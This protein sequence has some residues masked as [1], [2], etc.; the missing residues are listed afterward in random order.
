MPE[1]SPGSGPG[2]W[3]LAATVL[4]A[5][6]VFL[7]GSGVSIALPSIQS[8]FAGQLSGLQWVVNAYLLTLAALLPIGGS[9][10]DRFGRKRVLL[11]GMI[12]FASAGVLSAFARSIVQLTAFQAIQGI[13]SALVVPQNLAI[14][15]V[16]FAEGKRGQVI[17]L[18][19]G[20]SGAVSALGPWVSGWLVEHFSWSAVFFLSVLVVVAAFFISYVFVPESRNQ[21]ARRVDWLGASLL[22]AALFG[23]VYGLISGPSDWTS[24]LVLVSLVGGVVLFLLFIFAEYH[25]R[26]PAVPLRIFRSPLVSGANAATLM[27]YTALNGITLFSV[28]NLQQVHGYSP[29]LAGLALLPT[30]VCITLLSAPAGSMADRNGPRLQMVV[31]PLLVAVG[32]FWLSAWAYSG[33]YLLGFFPG[34]LVLGLGMA[35]LIAPLTKSALLVSPEL[36]G[37]ASGVNNAVSRVAS[38]LA[39]AVLGAIMLSLFSARLSDSLSGSGLSGDQQLAI[40]AQAG[41]LGGVVIPDGFDVVARANAEHVV[42]DSFEYAYRWAMATCSALALGGAVVSL[43]T[44]RNPSKIK[45]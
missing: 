20:L 45:T 4:S 35:T 31:G 37:A 23:I 12:V 19:A 7:L 39:V 2:R 21:H 16:S 5:A 40:S 1:Y 41:K 26:E 11:V 14:I 25:Q 33:G 8:H 9:L 18:W 27:V 32:A 10:G 17:G 3:V 34:F 6:A 24:P 43:F 22:F 42:S 29:S 38:L 28:L 44:I 15:N 36:S 13:G 30:I